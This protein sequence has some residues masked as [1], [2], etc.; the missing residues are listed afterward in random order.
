M[1]TKQ[2]KDDLHRFLF[3]VA[4]I[5]LKYGFSDGSVLLGAGKAAHMVEVAQY[6]LEQIDAGNLVLLTRDRGINL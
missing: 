4:G 3:D 5:N 1:D 2:L 6:L